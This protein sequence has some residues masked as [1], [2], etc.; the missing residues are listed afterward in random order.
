M[1]NPQFLSCRTFG[2]A[3][4]LHNTESNCGRVQFTLVCRDCKARRIDLVGRNGKE[5][6][7]RYEYPDG[8]QFV[9]EFDNDLVPTRQ[10]YRRELIERI[11]GG[12]K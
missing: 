11:L 9:R 3:W 6:T 8:Y 10:D 4:K 2:H 1:T 7:R 5:P 12:N